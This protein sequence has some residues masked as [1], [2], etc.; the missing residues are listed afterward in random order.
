[1]ELVEWNDSYSVGNVLMDAHHRVFFGMV[2][3]FS[4]SPAMD[5]PDAMMK[6]IAFLVEYT[7]MHLGAEEKL[8][9]QAGYPELEQHK[10]VHAAFARQILVAKEAF[11]KDQES[12]TPDQILEMMQDWFLHH[13]VGEDKKYMPFVLQQT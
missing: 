12:V 8:M 6:R 10:K 2:K 1:V 7:A 4:E 13:I 11:F 9:Q 5:D 3:E